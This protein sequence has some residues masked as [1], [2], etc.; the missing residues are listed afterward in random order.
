MKVSNLV[1]TYCLLFLTVYTI[2]MQVGWFMGLEEPTTLTQMVFTVMG[3]EFGVL[4][5]IKVAKIKKEGA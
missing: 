5:F 2:T 3:V 1:L 4:A